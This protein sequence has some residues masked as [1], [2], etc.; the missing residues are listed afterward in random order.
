MFFFILTDSKMHIN[1]YYLGRDVKKE[2][3][4]LRKDI[5][6]RVHNSLFQT[7]LFQSPEFHYL[8]KEEKDILKC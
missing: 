3:Y 6:D 8:N 4:N 5:F 1:I 2:I 7:Y